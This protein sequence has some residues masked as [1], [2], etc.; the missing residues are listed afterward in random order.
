MTNPEQETQKAVA[1]CT[2]TKI[3]GQPTNRDI[4]RLEDELIA[5]ASSFHSDLGGGLHGHAGLVKSIADYELI[6]PGTPFIFPANPGVYPQGVIPAAQRPQREAE[7]KALIAQFQTCVGASKGLKDLVLKAVEEDYL[8][9]LRAVGIAYLNVTPLQMLTH[10]RNRWG[11]MDYVDITALLTECDA[12]WNAAE[13]PEKYFNR[14]DESRRQLARSNVQVDERAMVAKALKSFKDAGDYDAAIREWEARPAAAQTY[15]NLRTLMNT[16]FTKLN[17]QDATT[18][19]ATGH[20]SV[21]NVVEEMAK[22]TE[23]LV[24]E[25]TER[26]G[27]QVET[28]MKSTSEALEKLTAAILANKPSATATATGNSSGKLS[29]K[30][31]IW[32]EKKKNATTCPHCTRIHPNRTHDQ[33]WE[34]P[35]NAAKRPANWKSAKST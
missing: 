7:H 33:C 19:R 4:D 10:L 14:M 18:A 22:A 6:A 16:E 34:L 20:S 8:L 27:K 12:P 24:A 11:T 17:R 28:L 21:N 9:E 29:A 1:E 32:A 25:L 2:V 3:Y 30:A 23:E 26:Q 35:A 13:V 5:I 15:A 31:A